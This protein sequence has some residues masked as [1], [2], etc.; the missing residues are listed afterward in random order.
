[1]QME[2]GGSEKLVHNLI[3]NLDRTRFYPSVA[4]FYG[5][6]PLTEYR[7]LEVP[8]FHIPKSRRVDL[9]CLKKLSE[10]IKKNEIEVVNAHHFM[11]MVYGSWGCLRHGTR[12]L[13]TEHS[14]WEIEKIDLKWRIL[15]R[16]LLRKAH[17]VIGVSQNVSNTLQRTFRLPANKVLTIRNGVDLRAFSKRSDRDAVRRE[18]GWKHHHIVIGTVANLKKVKNHIFLLR[19]F[20]ALS[21]KYDNVRLVLI[22]K[23]IPDND[24]N[25]ESAI[26]SFIDAGGLSEKVLLLGFRPDVDRLLAGFDMFCLTSLKE[27][28][29]IGMIEAMAAGLPVVGTHVEGIKDVIIPEYNGLMVPLGDVG[30]F[31]TTLERLTGDEFLRV[32]MGRAARETAT[33]QFSLE[34][35]VHAHEDLFRS[36]A[37][38]IGPNGS[39]VWHDTG[40]SW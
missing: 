2:M 11:S 38:P 30:N 29:P 20:E 5:H 34:A 22:G 26:R 35:C 21:R 7:Q 33:R 23:G 4:W 10:V 27:G 32:K 13:Y 19:G 18:F 1:M 28:L 8:L 15:G 16:Q 17:K 25:T 37:N 40:K 24:D 9:D 3:Q 31:C 12:M 39:G 14:S 36:A 6:T